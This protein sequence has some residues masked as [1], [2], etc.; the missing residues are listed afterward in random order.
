MTKKMI[1]VLTAVFMSTA[2]T[3]AQEEV[4]ASVE[5]T[6]VSKYI[7]RGQDLGHAA[8]QPSLGIAWKGI[9]LSAWG[10]WGIVDSNDTE[11]LDLT[12]GYS[13]NGLNIG[14]TD[15]WFNVG[16]AGDKYFRYK[17]H[18][19]NHV[20]E[21]NVGYDF[22][23]LALQWYTNLAG[24]DGVN[25]DGKRAYS[26]YFEISAPF[27]LASCEW[28]AA[29]GIVPHATTLYGTTGFD[30]TNINLQATKDLQIS[31]SFVMPVFAG[32][33][34]NPCAEKFYFYF[35]VTLRP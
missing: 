4:E 15:Y 3:M 13:T 17:A 16:P 28:S 22:G 30:V 32:L 7:W 14:L 25:E 20:L 1:L 29:L 12:L 10:N 34:A 8:I 26:S 19:T 5:A 2:A 27:K 11:E 23:V 18:E 24:N 6:F 31:E 35:G 33:T 21:G 9:S